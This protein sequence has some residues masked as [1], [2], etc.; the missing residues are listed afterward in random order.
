MLNVERGSLNSS[1]CTALRTLK[2]EKAIIEP[3]R[4]IISTPKRKQRSLHPGKHTVHTCY[5]EYCMTSAF[6]HASPMLEDIARV[7]VK[8]RMH[9][10][11]SGTR[12]KRWYVS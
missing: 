7:F 3:V 12:G 6:I 1:T 9:S 10:S 8:A 5:S 2:I 11:A 4:L